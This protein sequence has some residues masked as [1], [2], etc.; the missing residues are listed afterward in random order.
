MDAR[1]VYRTFLK[2][3]PWDYRAAFA[4]EML[5][6]FERNRTRVF[7]ECAGLVI[8]ACREWIAKLT[9]D[10]A[11]RGRTL[12]DIRMMRPAGISREVWFRSG[13]CSSDISR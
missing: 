4:W 12:P 5:A 10:R 3:Y 7:S 6:A 2:L 13:G 9:T 11:V 8:G 1:R